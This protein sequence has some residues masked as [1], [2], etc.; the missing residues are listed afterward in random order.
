MGT[1]KHKAPMK[2]S[3]KW[4]VAYKVDMPG[5]T[6]DLEVDFSKISSRVHKK[7]LYAVENY[8]EIPKQF[9]YS[10]DARR[11]FETLRKYHGLP[12]YNINHLIK[13][14]GLR[15]PEL[16]Q[17][18]YE[19]CY[20]D[21]VAKRMERGEDW[22]LRNLVYEY[23][24]GKHEGNLSYYPGYGG[25]EFEKQVEQSDVCKRVKQYLQKQTAPVLEKMYQT[26]AYGG[27]IR[28]QLTN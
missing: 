16:Y 1:H 28:F 2:F 23:E 10:S 25:D 14:H 7:V 8:P 11:L 20:A 19:F 12:V 15:D 17:E 4:D 9:G 21:A 24:S 22:T 6:C 13:V 27:C 26:V 5:V 18:L 3:S